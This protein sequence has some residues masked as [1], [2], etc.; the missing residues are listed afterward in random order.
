MYELRV[1]MPKLKD[2]YFHELMKA[3]GS[4]EHFT[5]QRYAKRPVFSNSRER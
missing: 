4:T 1:F 5:D 3:I 2:D